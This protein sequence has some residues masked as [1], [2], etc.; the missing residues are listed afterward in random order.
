MVLLGAPAL[1]QEP[2]RDAV[3]DQVVDEVGEDALESQASRPANVEELFAAFAKMEG[4]EARFEEEKHLA[5]LAVPL[6][7]RGRIYFLPPGHLA[8]VVEEPEPST[9]TISPTELRMSGRDGVETIDLRTS[10]DVR[11]FVTS[12]V[13]VFSGDRE[14]L[15]RAYEVTFSISEEDELSWVLVLTPRKQPL[16][17]VMRD[18]RLD[19]EGFAV[20][21]IEIREPNGDRTTTRIV[22]AD[23]ARKFSAE[24]KD[25]LFGV[26]PR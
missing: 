9:L 13:H 17:N 25:R 19:G 18:L 5:L 15:R 12:L 1:A 10:D 26:A 6:K 3:R 4:L 16:S 23:P 24:E 7:S 22:E 8:R 11:S 21:G 2:A 20:T 14:A